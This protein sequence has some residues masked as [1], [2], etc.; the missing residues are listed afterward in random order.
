[1]SQMDAPRIRKPKRYS[2]LIGEVVE[3]KPFTVQR[4]A[5]IDHR[6]RLSI[7]QELPGVKVQYPDTVF[8]RQDRCPDGLGVGVRV[9]VSVV[10]K[11]NPDATK[12]PY[13]DAIAVQLV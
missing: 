5:E 11:N 7:L 6:A 13:L 9:H 10:H 12:P 3:L 8:L 4:G 1:M 2:S